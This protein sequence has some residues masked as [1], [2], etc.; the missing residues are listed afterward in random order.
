MEELREVKVLVQQE[1]LSLPRVGTRKLHF[2]LQE[3]LASQQIKIGRDALFDFLRSEHLLIRPLK[4]YRKTT[5][6]KHWLHKHPNLIKNYRPEQAE[7]LW[8]ADITYIETRQETGYLSL[9]TD[10]FSRKIVGHHLHPSLHTDGVLKAFK[11][12]LRGAFI[13]TSLDPSF[14]SGTAI[15]LCEVSSRS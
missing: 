13:Y 14:G 6:S 1:R 5:N 7:E 12:A 9:I 2:L 3:H 15:L 8:V 4:S 10:A 11:K